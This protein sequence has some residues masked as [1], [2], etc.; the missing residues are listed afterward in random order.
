MFVGVVMERAWLKW[1]VA[2][3][4]VVKAGGRGQGEVGI[5]A[6]WGRGPVGMG[7]SVG[8]VATMG[9]GGGKRGWAWP[10]K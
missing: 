8:G 5:G 9:V 10:C 1:G 4:G 7:V 6:V 2:K 3:G